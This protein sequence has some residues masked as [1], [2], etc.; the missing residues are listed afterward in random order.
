MK[1]QAK[2]CPT[3][4]VVIVTYNSADVIGAC[5]DACSELDTV[6]VDNASTD[7]TLVRVKS[8]S[9]ARTIENTVNTGFAAAVNQGVAAQNHAFILLLNP[10]VEMTTPVEPAI[11][12][13]IAACHDPQTGI[14]S[15]KLL[16]MNGRPQ[17]GFNI[18]R[19][20]T[21]PAL[22]FEVLGLNR[23]W[24]GNPV[25]RRYR[26]LDVDRDLAR[27]V[28]QPAGA[29]LLFRRSLW[30]QL[31][32]FD[33]RFYPLW[34]EDVDFCKRARDL[35]W[36]TRYLPTVTA[37]HLGAHSIQKLDWACREAYWYASLLRYASKHFRSW[38]F[39]G[40]SA[41]VV[42]GSILRVVGGV[43]SRRNFQPVAVY[44]K[45][46]RLAAM[47]LITGRVPGPMVGSQMV[48]R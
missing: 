33:P 39:R 25:N 45:V 28:E 11:D 35:G 20:P 15:G 12:A 10:D 42:L 7:E 30:T 17:T 24:P 4:G 6:V 9:W 8:R 18:R 31:N 32:G 36:K 27:D 22:T 16:D 48:A 23:L 46:G 44:A 5:L 3:V 38:A 47:S 37:R 1:G 2:A 21:A 26:C 40:V 29:F 34:Y 41:A 14:V 19:F 43:V 13:L